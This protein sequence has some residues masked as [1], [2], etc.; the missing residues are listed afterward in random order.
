M[1]A[2]PDRSGRV[3]AFCGLVENF[4]SLKTKKKK[5]NPAGRVALCDWLEYY[6]VNIRLP[7]WLKQ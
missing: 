1:W 6:R 7:W 2:P 3:N 4:Y 5:K